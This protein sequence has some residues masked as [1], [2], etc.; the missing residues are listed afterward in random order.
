MKNEWNKW[1]NHFFEMKGDVGM[2][3]HEKEREQE[4]A[5]T[6]TQTHTPSLHLHSTLKLCLFV[7]NALG[8]EKI[9][10][11]NWL[12]EIH[13]VLERNKDVGMGVMNEFVSG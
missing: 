6:Q 2:S 9:F 12:H 3:R 11:S 7:V 4:D 5:F 1:K 10:T 13:C 8:K